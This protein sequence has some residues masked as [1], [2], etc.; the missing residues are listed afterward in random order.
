NN[1]WKALHGYYSDPAAMRYT[2]GQPLT[3]GATWRAMASMVGH[4]QLHGYGP[5]C[6]TQKKDSKIVGVV[7]FWYPA[8][9][10]EPEIKWGLIPKFW[11]QGF[12]SEAARQVLQV[13]LEHLP[14]LRLIS[15]IDARNQSSIHVATAMGATLEKEVDF[16]DARFQI[17]RHRRRK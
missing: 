7:G 9:W 14:H 16:R 17:Y 5:Y 12:A 6:V 2:V 13:G 1:D 4:W 10:P 8:D 15:F 11:G 3:E